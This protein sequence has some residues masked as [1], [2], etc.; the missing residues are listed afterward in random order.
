[1]KKIKYICPECFLIQN[2]VSGIFK[3]LYR[4]DY[5]EGEEVENEFL[6]GEYT[7][8]VFDECL[9]LVEVYDIEDIEVYIDD[10]DKEIGI[11][12]D[13]EK[14][15]EKIREAN[16]EYRDYKFKFI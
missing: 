2:K 9:H 12:K 10:E 16:P 11:L 13:F 8:V 14:Y 15:E 1:M 5:S 4:I 3:G 6:D 7:H